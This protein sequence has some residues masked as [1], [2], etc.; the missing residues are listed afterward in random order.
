MTRKFKR[1]M[2]FNVDGKVPFSEVL[3]AWCTNNPDAE[4]FSVELLTIKDSQ[5]LFLVYYFVDQNTTRE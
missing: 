1:V 2:S 4:I 5:D 3:N